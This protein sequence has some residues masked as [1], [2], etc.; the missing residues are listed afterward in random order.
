[1]PAY[2]SLLERLAAQLNAGQISVEEVHLIL[3][4]P[5]RLLSDEEN[6]QLRSI[7]PDSSNITHPGR[8]DSY[9]FM[10]NSAGSTAEHEIRLPQA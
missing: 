1:M 3:N 9:E 10:D 2:A 8:S 4:Y 7:I 5:G 6:N